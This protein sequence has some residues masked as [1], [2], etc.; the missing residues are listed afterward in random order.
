MD[1]YEA[2][3]DCKRQAQVV[4]KEVIEKSTSRVSFSVVCLPDTVDTRGAKTR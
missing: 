1:S 2:R 4:Q 3:D